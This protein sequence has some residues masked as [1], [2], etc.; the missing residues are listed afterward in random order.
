[1]T[2]K[3]IF[4]TSSPSRVR[5]MGLSKIHHSGDTY[6]PEEWAETIRAVSLL[7]EGDRVWNPYKQ[8]WDTLKSVTFR[9][10][11]ICSITIA[12]GKVKSR[13]FGKSLLLGFYIETAEGDFVYEYIKR[14]DEI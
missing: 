12:N 7:K 10:S 11:Q 2:F 13:C 1:M 4:G 8:G 3:A 14:F 6:S 5:R 9:R